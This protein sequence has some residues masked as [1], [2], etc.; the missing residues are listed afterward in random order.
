[1][2]ADAFDDLRSLW[3]SVLDTVM[4]GL[5]ADALGPESDF[6]DWGGNSVWA[7][8]LVTL[9]S[10]R[11]AIDVPLSF[12]FDHPTLADQAEWLGRALSDAGPRGD[13]GPPSDN[14]VE[15]DVVPLMPVQSFFLRWIGETSPP[16]VVSTVA[17]AMQV[18][19]KL[20]VDALE[21]AVARLAERHPSLRLAFPS[22]YAT[23]AVIT[24]PEPGE[25]FTVETVE[26]DD[27]GSV[28]AEVASRHFDIAT[29]PLFR[30]AAVHTGVDRTLL[31]IG[32]HHL[33][34][35]GWSL[36][37]VVQELTELYDAA[38]HGREPRLSPAGLSY[39]AYAERVRRQVEL[40]DDHWERVLRGAPN[41]LEPFPTRG[42]AHHY[43]ASSIPIQVPPSLGRRLASVC[44]EVGAT[45]YMGVVACWVDILAEWSG[46]ADVV[47][48]TPVPGRP[49]P[50][51][52]PL[53]GC[54]VQ[55]LLVRV[56]VSGEP[57]LLDLTGRVRAALLSATEHQFYAYEKF[58][59]TIRYPAW[60]TIEG[61]A[62][63]SGA[64][65]VVRLETAERD[66]GGL[67]AET[68]DLPRDLMFD[69]PLL[70]N[71]VERSVP[72]L[73]LAIAPD[74]AMNGVLVYNRLAYTEPAVERLREHLLRLVE[75]ASTLPREPLRVMTK[76]LHPTDPGS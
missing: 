56:D 26:T 39:T 28:A 12:A 53:V 60:I 52:N 69:W 22:L 61:S 24:R 16:R 29:G 21:G 42:L 9:L 75:L 68:V 32:A 14:A 51:A 36:G 57:S 6:F 18:R 15:A 30:V 54:L 43:T 3:L 11:H 45:L 35:D 31:V 65:E 10:E 41:A 46:S 55:S 20:D 47:V 38:V 34:I 40:N 63:R 64:G 2:T 33:V 1:M 58:S 49:T 19:G 8:Q 70:E 5:P 27:P 67:P 7:A 25:L 62:P 72:E 66:F 4:P 37:I 13:A 74:G 50:E 73:N 76:R 17:T 59:R 44:R 48:M 71:E 23:T